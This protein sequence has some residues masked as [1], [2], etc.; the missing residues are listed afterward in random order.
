MTMTFNK[1]TVVIESYHREIVDR[2]NHLQVI[3]PAIPDAFLP[4]RRDSRVLEVNDQ[5][6]APFGYKDRDDLF[7]PNIIEFVPPGQRREA[8]NRG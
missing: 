5:C 2:G 6:I 4:M 3:L 8:F 1:M 7:S